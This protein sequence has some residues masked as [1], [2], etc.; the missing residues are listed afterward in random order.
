MYKVDSMAK[1][2]FQTAVDLS[3]LPPGTYR[4]RT[5]YDLANGSGMR[6]AC[7]GAFHV[8]IGS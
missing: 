3:A 1:S 7:N 6:L 2:G 5:V 8:R 4:L